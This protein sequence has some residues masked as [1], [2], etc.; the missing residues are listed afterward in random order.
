[1]NPHRQR[2][3]M[4]KRTIM[5]GI[6]NGLL[7]CMLLLSCTISQSAHV[8]NEDSQFSTESENTEEPIELEKKYNVIASIDQHVP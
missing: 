6:F 5:T 8:L 1:M 4:S 3:Y 2:L 7:G